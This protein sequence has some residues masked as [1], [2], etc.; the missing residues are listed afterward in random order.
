MACIYSRNGILWIKFY[1]VGGKQVRQSLKLKDD[2]E[3]RNQAKMAQKK[4][5]ADLA[6]D[7]VGVLS[8]MSKTKPTCK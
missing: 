1:T 4:I 8:R 3:G 7:P 5:E 2:R 6:I